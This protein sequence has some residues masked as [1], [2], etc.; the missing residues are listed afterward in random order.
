MAAFD[1]FITD[2]IARLSGAGRNVAVA[3]LARDGRLSFDIWQASR[4]HAAH[5]LEINRRVAVL[6]S[7]ASFEP[8]VKLFQHFPAVDEPTVSSVLKINLPRVSAFL[9]QRPS[10]RCS[11]DEFADALPDLLD[12]GDREAL[13]SDTR[14]GLLTYIRSAIPNFD[15]VTDLVIIDL[16]YS[17]SIQKALRRL[18][19]HEGIAVRLHGLYLLSFD[20]RF[21]ELCETDTA[22]GFISD[23]VVKPRVNRI[24]ARNITIL[25]HACCAPEGSV[26]GYRNGTPLRE[27]DPRPAGQLALCADIQAGVLHFVDHLAEFSAAEGLDP[28]DDLDL[29]A[30][31]AAA[32]LARLLLLPTDDELQLLGGI[33]H[34]INL[35]TQTLVAMADPAAAERFNVALALPSLCVASEPPMWMAG[36]MSAL[37][38][39]HGFLYALF[40]VGHL[41]GD[42]FADARCGTL[43]V[44]AISAGSSRSFSVSCFRCSFG[45]IRV[46]I[47][48]LRSLGMLAIS[49]PLGRLMPEGLIL[50]IAV[51]TGKTLADAAS[52]RQVQNLARAARTGIGIA[53]SGDH[54]QATGTDADKLLIRLPVL[55][56]AVGIVTMLVKPLCGA[57]ALALAD[58]Q[59]PAAAAS[60]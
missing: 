36:T 13:A 7:A 32:I 33:Q 50:G 12:D 28:F 31:R 34:D 5:Y 53:L 57:R 37:S 42:I 23:L 60:A 26:R 1:R 43:D 55:G 21:A 24:I 17:A 15:S 45:D 10:G 3:F 29:A 39:A 22:E 59:S 20:D 49:I 46:R 58:E 6:G 8:L 14:E 40:G 9:R 11:G 48:I 54:F 30:H 19:D 51:Q 44:E 25:E 18:L 56:E 16:G 47:P 4:D 52:N 41:P 2:R 38:P 27:P 35:G